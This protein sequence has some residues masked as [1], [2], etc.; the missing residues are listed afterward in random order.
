MKVEG[1]VIFHK[2]QNKIPD[3]NYYT[4]EVIMKY[5]ITTLSKRGETE[6]GLKAN[7]TKPMQGK[8]QRMWNLRMWS[9]INYLSLP[10]YLL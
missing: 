9:D 2:F 1:K 8:L 5:T 3:G 7:K 10:N 4:K 6:M